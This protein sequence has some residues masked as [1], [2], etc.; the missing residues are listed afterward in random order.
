M[1]TATC[2][3]HP[4]PDTPTSCFRST[5][6]GSA[7]ACASASRSTTVQP[8]GCSCASA[9]L[10]HAANRAPTTTC[11]ST[12]PPAWV[13]ATASSAA[14]SM[15]VG[16]TCSSRSASRPT[17][18]ARGALAAGEQKAARAPPPG[19]G[20]FDTPTRRVE[21]YSEP[22]LR[23]GQPP[24]ATFVEPADTPSDAKATRQGRFPYV[25]SSAKNGFYCHS[26]HR[27]LPSLRKRAPDPV[28]ELSP[29]LAAAKGIVDGDWMRIRT[30]VGEARFVARVTPQL[31]DDVI[32]AEFGWWQS[33]PELDR[34]GLPVEGALGSNFNALISADSC[35]PVSGSVPHRSFLCHIERDPAPQKRQRQGARYRPFRISALRPEA[36]G[37]LGIHFEPVDGGELP[38][39]RPGQHIEMQLHLDD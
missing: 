37:V 4:P 35:D 18:C 21:L 10:R 39:Y 14:A 11:C 3:K 33:C 32:V 15:R 29:V 28:A 38:D 13:W 25:L 24:V 6:P 30:R 2:S 5:H 26:Q 36:D 19:V 31:G 16:T 8:A 22:L 34:D 1:C 23:H 17:R 27:S 9:W 12:W 7:K 20:G